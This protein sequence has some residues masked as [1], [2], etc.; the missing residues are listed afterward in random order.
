VNP[1]FWSGRRVLVTGHTGFKGSWLALWLHSMGAHTVGFSRRERDAPALYD[2]AGV[3]DSVE[4]IEG[5]IRD[6]EAVTRAVESARPDVV[7][8]MA[9]QPIVRRS[10]A[11]PAET[12]AT[13]VMGTVNVLEAVRRAADVR[14]LV[15]VTTDKVY[16]NRGWVWPYRE[17][18][19]LGGE[20]PY[21]A[22]KAAAELATAAYRHSFSEDGGARIATA[23]AGNVI[24]GGD[25]A[26]D[27]LVPDVMRAALDGEPVV[28]RNPHMERPWQHVLCALHGYLLLC[29]RLWES[30]DFADA[31]NF[32]PYENDVLPV[33]A[34]VERLGRLWPGGIRI[35]RSW[36]QAAPAE[37]HTLK[38]DSAKAHSQLRW[39]P[40]WDLDAALRAIVDWYAA[41]G[42][43]R[44]MREVTLGQIGEY[45]RPSGNG[46]Q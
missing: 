24:G 8:H 18:E 29:E 13:N 45:S 36:E 23:R 7:L 20:D 3:N 19:P 25:W 40:R 28:I 15:N 26:P 10:Y 6:A 9:A 22:S 33:G 38:L 21:S 31:W 12:F 30:G 35:E 44:D 1:G 11:E 2:L 5:D 4:F 46:P 27:R 41:Y 34:I 39:A 37:A 42:E 32:G 16:L 14:V 43:R 17:P